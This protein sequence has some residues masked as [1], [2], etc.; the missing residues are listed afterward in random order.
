MLSTRIWK[1]HWFILLL[2]FGSTVVILS[3][4]LPRKSPMLQRTRVDVE[5]AQIHAAI[6]IFQ[7]EFGKL[8]RGDSREVF[9][10][11]LGKNP[12]RQAFIL[13][14]ASFVSA[15]G[16]LVDPWGTPYMVYFSGDEVLIRSA[17][18]NRRFDQSSVRGFDDRIR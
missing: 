11:L 16:N 12:K 17:G 9:G 7:S 18:P 5:E 8:P 1:R 10:A 6:R 14:P 2:I 15:D 3:A 4:L 13:G